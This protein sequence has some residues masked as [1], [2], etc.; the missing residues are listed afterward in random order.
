MSKKKK[1][2]KCTRCGKPSTATCGN[3]PYCYPCG[4]CIFSYKKDGKVV[5]KYVPRKKWKQIQYEDGEMIQ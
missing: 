3:K 4:I 2:T 1:T 5:S